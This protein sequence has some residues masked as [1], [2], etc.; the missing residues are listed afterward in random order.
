[1]YKTTHDFINIITH[2]RFEAW[3]LALLMAVLTYN[4]SA[5][6]WIL[7]LTFPMF[8]LSMI[9]YLFNSRSGAQLYNLVHNATIPTLLI[10]LGALF[11]QETVS[12][13]GFCWTFHIAIDRLLGFGLKFNH[14]FHATHMGEINRGR[15][16][17]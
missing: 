17:K 13:V 10:A 6:L 1:M 5:P 9:G 2:L 8:D 14:S 7:A 11:G 12:V 16:Q 3:S 4:S 15:W